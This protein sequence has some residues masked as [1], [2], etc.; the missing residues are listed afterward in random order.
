MPEQTHKEGGAAFRPGEQHPE[1]WRDDLNPDRLAG[2][3]VGVTEQ[4]ARTA[5]DLKDA[6]RMLEG[7]TDDGLKQIPVL[8]PGTR[9]EQG[10]TYIDLRDPQRREFTATGDMEA[11]QDNWYVPKDGVDYQLWNRLIGIDNPERLYSAPE[12]PPRRDG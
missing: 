2:Q 10:A 7:I 11:G 6:H 9:L 8:W 12:G 1:R 3:N 4:R 5:Y